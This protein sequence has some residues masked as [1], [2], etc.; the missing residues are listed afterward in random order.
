MRSTRWWRSSVGRCP[1]RLARSTACEATSRFFDKYIKTL[2]AGVQIHADF[3]GYAPDRFRPYRL[4]SAVF[5]SL[6]AVHPGFELW[7]DFYYEYEPAHRR[8]VDVINGGPSLREW[9][10]DPRASPADW[11]Q[12]LRIDEDAWIE[13][14][15]QFLIYT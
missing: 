15:R 12:A 4:I 7:R 3:P 9:V 10:D 11:D 1:R 5:K 8:P 6:R 2:C 14:R 13:E